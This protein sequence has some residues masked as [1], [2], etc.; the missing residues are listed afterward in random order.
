MEAVDICERFSEEIFSNKD[1]SNVVVRIKKIYVD[2]LTGL[3]RDINYRPKTVVRESKIY[4]I[5]NFE[6]T[7]PFEWISD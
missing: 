6:K 2:D 3:L 1:A 7:Y 5:I 4:Y